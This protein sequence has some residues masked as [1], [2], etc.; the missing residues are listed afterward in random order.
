MT[1]MFNTE[2]KVRIY[3]KNTGFSLAEQ[4]LGIILG[5]PTRVHLNRTHHCSELVLA[6]E[7]ELIWQVSL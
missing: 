5:C 2:Y 1:L 4:I 6:N 3:Q 7:E